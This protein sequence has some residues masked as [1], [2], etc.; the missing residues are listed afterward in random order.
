M[1]LTT[2]TFLGGVIHIGEVSRSGG[3]EGD[4]AA[5]RLAV[6][7][8]DLA[9]PLGRLK[10]GTPPRLDGRTIDYAGLTTQ[11]G[12]DEPTML[13]FLSAA[14][15]APQLDCH[16]AHTNGATHEIIRGNLARSAMYSG[17][18]RGVGPRYCPS[19][20]DKV[21]RFPERGSHQVFLEPEGVAD[22][23]VYP[24]GI[25]TS[26]PAEVQEACVRS[27]R[28]LERARILRPG[29]AI[30][31]DYVDP[32]ALRPSL[33]MKALPG[34]FLAGQINGTT[35]YEEAAAQGLI[36]GLNAGF[37]ATGREP[38]VPG[39][40][41]SYIGVMVDDLVTR[42]VA[43]PYRMFTSRAEYRLI[44]R[45]DNAD[46]RLTPLGHRLGCVSDGRYRAFAAKMRR[47]AAGREVA[48]SLRLTPSEG[49]RAG[50][51]MNRDGIRR[52]AMELLAYPGMTVARLAE[53]WPE[54]ALLDG[55][56][57]RQLEND[58]C[59]AGYLARQREA[60]A[61]IRREEALTLPPDLDY[62]A[63]SGLSA[64]LRE[65]LAAVR[66][67]TMGQAARIDGMTPAALALVLAAA[68]RR[69]EQRRRA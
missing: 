2:G 60:A 58:A 3:R 19:I 31:Y 65:K 6:R 30:E 36:A 64:E 17:K 27:I 45:A 42:G 24:N 25:S 41:D 20:E 4:P 12:D 16:V 34:L 52:S 1:V 37:A 21:A 22:D 9:L 43:E 14:P 55:T 23:T 5:T 50:V 46:R 35:G 62:A 18:I 11:P 57:A 13:S 61:A 56:T 38:V 40:A 26:L 47:R 7:L 51:T 49:R 66:P 15:Q 44:L 68:R 48:E 63:L 29:Y 8:R 39:R 10:T 32:R 67:E 28:G 33:E 54:L 69:G 59:Y 53:I